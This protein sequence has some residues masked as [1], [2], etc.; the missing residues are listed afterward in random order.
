MVTAG[1]IVVLFGKAAGRQEFLYSEV[2]ELN[3]SGNF[4]ICSDIDN[5]K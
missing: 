5:V 2:S 3:D 1:Y 4:W